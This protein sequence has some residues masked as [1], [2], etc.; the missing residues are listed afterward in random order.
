MDMGDES[1]NNNSTTPSAIG[2]RSG[3]SPEA[4]RLFRVY[5]TI[6]AMLKKRDYSVPR[7]LLE[8]TPATFTNKFGEH[9]SRDSLTIL[10]V[11]NII[12]T[13]N[14]CDIYIY[15]CQHLSTNLQFSYQLKP[16]FH[17]IRKKPTMNKTNCLYFSL[18]TKK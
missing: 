3:L 17:F 10:V 11:C 18:K 12:T 5:K 2:N 7:E 9:P 13:S 8:M 14:F 15:A 6:A 1:Q 16:L 4:S